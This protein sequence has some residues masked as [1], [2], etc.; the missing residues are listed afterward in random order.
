MVKK[1]KTPLYF[2]SKQG[3]IYKVKTT[4]K[5][6]AKNSSVQFEKCYQLGHTKRLEY[7]WK[8]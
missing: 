4:R 1:F 8:R 7:G 6:P 2:T 5:S 3:D